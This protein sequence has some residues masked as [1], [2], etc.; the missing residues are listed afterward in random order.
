LAKV[1]KPNFV[2][3][4]KAME[5]EGEMIPKVIPK[6]GKSSKVRKDPPNSFFVKLLSSPSKRGSPLFMNV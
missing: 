2:K 3:V 4:T 5:N 6:L 1:K